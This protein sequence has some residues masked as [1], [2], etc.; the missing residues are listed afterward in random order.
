MRLAEELK[1][2]WRAFRA[3]ARWTFSSALIWEWYVTTLP[4]EIANLLAGLATWYYYGLM[5]GRENLPMLR[6]YGGNFASFLL[7]GV[8][9]N[10]LFSYALT[11]FVWSV[12][13]AF[14]STVMSGA[15]RLNLIDYFRM[16]RI[17]FRRWLVAK[18]FLDS[19]PHLLYASAYLIGGILVFGI[20]LPQRANVLGAILAL[21]LGVTALMGISMAGAGFLLA[22]RSPY[23]RD[24]VTWLVA[25]LAN[26]ASGVYFPPEVLPEPLRAVSWALP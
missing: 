7:T 8:A 11:C 9:A 20:D 12:R 15:S 19:V 1:V 6:A 13:A 22:L 24:S 23:G 4:F 16:A 18:A 26:I 3:I 17:S 2:E 21:L 5:F 14:A 25:L 10:T